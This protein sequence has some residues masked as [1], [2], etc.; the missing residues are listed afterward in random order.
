MALQD[1]MAMQL[2]Y[3]RLAEMQAAAIQ[4]SG[5]DPNAA[6]AAMLAGPYGRNAAATAGAHGNV[7]TDPMRNPKRQ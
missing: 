7:R 1:P 2:H 6:M 3:Q 5:G 4:Q